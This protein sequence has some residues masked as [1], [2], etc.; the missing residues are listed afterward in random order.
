MKH[1]IS[2]LVNNRP[3]VLARTAGLFA[4]RGFNIDSL[5]VS[6]T[7]D[8]AMSRM[9]I[10]VDGPDHILEQISKQLY[11]LMDVIRVLDHQ[12]ED[13]VN[14]E[15]ALIKV[16][17][18]PGERAEIMQIVSIFRANIVDIAEKTFIIEVTGSADKVDALEKLLEKY[19]IREM[20]RTGRIVLSRG[21][22]TA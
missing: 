1:T 13:V 8:P 21:P 17:A 11:K 9:T 16:D 22:R 10:V 15:L 12:E 7:Q 20:M 2:V 6:T 5:A 4:R 3:G 18:E 19:G 14:R